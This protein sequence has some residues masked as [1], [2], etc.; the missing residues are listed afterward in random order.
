MVCTKDTK[1]KPNN[2]RALVVLHAAAMLLEQAK[3]QTL[4]LY[5]QVLNYNPSPKYYNTKYLYLQYMWMPLYD[6]GN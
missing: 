4:S 2:N 3:P 6:L 5:T 1:T